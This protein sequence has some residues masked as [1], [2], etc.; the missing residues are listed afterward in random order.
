MCL[1]AVLEMKV[2]YF[3]MKMV[4]FTL[5]VIHTLIQ[6]HIAVL[7]KKSSTLNQKKALIQTLSSRSTKLDR[8]PECKTLFEK[9]EWYKCPVWSGNRIMSPSV[10]REIFCCNIKKFR[11]IS[12]SL[13]SSEK[14]QI[15]DALKKRLSIL[16]EFL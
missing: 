5:F 11:K 8:C 4:R 7:L 12:N 10:F 15:L 16:D 13:P 3:F 1:L 6:Q 2:G 14:P 9:S